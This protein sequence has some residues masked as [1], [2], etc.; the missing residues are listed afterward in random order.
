MSTLKK[1]IP[2]IFFAGIFALVLW[3]TQPPKNLTSATIFQILLF[4]IPLFLLLIFLLN[5][6]FQFLVRSFVISLGIVLLLIFKS[7]E[8]L[9]FVSGILTVAAI[10]FLVV[11][12][13]KPQKFQQLKIQSLK[14]R[15]QH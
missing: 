4:F 5:I 3:Q 6:Y 15:K 1:L 11:S 12:F 10:I 8:T 2:V 13:K 7:L 9:N 14:L